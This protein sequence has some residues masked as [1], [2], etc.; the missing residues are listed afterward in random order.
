M[1]DSKYIVEITGLKKRY[2]GLMR[3]L[4]LTSRLPGEKS[5]DFWDQTAAG[6]R[7]C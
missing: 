2:P 3:L 5:G 4:A 7:R 1:T 6:N